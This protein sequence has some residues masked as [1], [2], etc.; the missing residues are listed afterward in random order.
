M[1]V[2][3]FKGHS[4]INCQEDVNRLRIHR[5]RLGRPNPLNS[6]MIIKMM[7]MM[8][9]RTLMISRFFA[10]LLVLKV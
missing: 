1:S 2:Q 10:G 9:S 8:T 4:V 7:M 6:T 3:G 5:N